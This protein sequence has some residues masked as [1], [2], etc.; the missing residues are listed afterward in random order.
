[1]TSTTSSLIG[2]A[3]ELLR[4]ARSAI[5]LTGAGVSTASGIPDFRSPRSG[6]WAEVD[7]MEVASLATF[8]YTPERFFDWVRPLAD[9]MCRAQ[10]N[11]A[12]LALA[13]LE[14]M[15]LLQGVI[16][17]NIDLLHS[18][19]G[20]R[21]V[22]EVHGSLESA[23]CVRCYAVWH[24]QPGLKAFVDYGQLPTC[25]DCGGLLK[26]NITLM[27]EQLSTGVMQAARQAARNCDVM[28]VAGSSLEVLPAANLPLEAFQFGAQIIVVNLQPTY[29]DDRATVRIQGNA[30]VILPQLAQQA[31]DSN[32]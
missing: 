10:P 18:R 8:R 28:L 22:L 15:G 2:T 6:L 21:R 11:P 16:T 25:A 5:A 32:A 4:R 13:Q 23:T 3:A 26:P 7:P 12:H 29:I 17:Q 27:G 1:M 30:A 31:G 14:A 9:L 20:S 24:D 19:A